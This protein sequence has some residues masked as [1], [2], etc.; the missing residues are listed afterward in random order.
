[1]LGAAAAA[2]FRRATFRRATFRWVTF[3][4]ATFRWVT[5]HRATFRWVH[6]ATFHRAGVCASTVECP[7]I[8]PIDERKPRENMGAAVASSAQG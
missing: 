8:E 2:S 4:R 6:R 1:M 5:F 3:R 7:A